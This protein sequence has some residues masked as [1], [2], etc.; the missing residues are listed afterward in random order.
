MFGVSGERVG[1]A[2]PTTERL[3]LHERFLTP[4]LIKSPGVAA[5][6]PIL[7]LRVFLDEI[8][9][10]NVNRSRVRCRNEAHRPVGTNHQPI[11]S[12]RFEGDI[13]KWDDLLRCP[14]L[15]VGFGN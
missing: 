4:Q 15:P 10:H 5:E 14:M 1:L 7:T 6:N 8:A 2:R 3:S 13:E 9:F 12:E 11:R